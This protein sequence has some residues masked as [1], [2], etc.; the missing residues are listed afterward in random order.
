VP[1]FTLKPLNNRKS[2]KCQATT[3]VTERPGKKPILV[4]KV[5]RL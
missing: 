4:E 1:N 3:G 5:T 2:M